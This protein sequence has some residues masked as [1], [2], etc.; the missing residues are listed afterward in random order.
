MSPH[1]SWRTFPWL[2]DASIVQLFL[3]SSWIW[4]LNWWKYDNIGF[5]FTGKITEDSMHNRLKCHLLLEH[6]FQLHMDYRNFCE[7]SW[8]PAHHLWYIF[9]IYFFYREISFQFQ[10][11]FVCIF[12]MQSVC[13]A[14]GGHMY[15]A[16]VRLSSLRHIPFQQSWCW[17]PWAAKSH[18]VF[19]V[20]TSPSSP[21]PSPH[22]PHIS[23]KW[24]YIINAVLFTH[25]LLINFSFLLT[26]FLGMILG[27]S[28]LRH[29]TP[30]P[31]YL[32]A[33]CAAPARQPGPLSCA[34]PISLLSLLQA[35]PPPQPLEMTGGVIGLS[36]QL[37]DESSS[38]RMCLHLLSSPGCPKQRKKVLSECWLPLTRMLL[39]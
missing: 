10:M 19:L 22:S 37:E 21:L 16:R 30:D 18:Q 39:E 17:A 36:L 33:L 15:L 6:V 25:S 34:G 35:S 31:R 7:V 12:G 2:V 24:V 29:S 11:T 9:V 27:A 26:P 8:T 32:P 38:S 20:E 1:G 14:S 5:G 23:H 28:T 4:S 3:G 13:T